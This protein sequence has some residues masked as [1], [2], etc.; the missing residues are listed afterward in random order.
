MSSRIST[1][2]IS[3]K[4][5]A[6]NHNDAEYKNTVEKTHSPKNTYLEEKYFIANT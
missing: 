1:S 6:T 5:G 2:V 4:T 3:A